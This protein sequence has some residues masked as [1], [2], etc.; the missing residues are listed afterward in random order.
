[1][2]EIERSST[3]VNFLLAQCSLFVNLVLALFRVFWFFFFEA[4]KT[5]KP[6]LTVAALILFQHSSNVQCGHGVIGLP[7]WDHSGSHS[8]A[9]QRLMACDKPLLSFYFTAG[10]KYEFSTALLFLAIEEK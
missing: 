2:S 10:A 6:A 1:M 3:C 7:G 4:L 9:L 8:C 5:H